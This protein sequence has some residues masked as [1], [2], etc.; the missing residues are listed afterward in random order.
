MDLA[1]YGQRKRVLK[2]GPMRHEIPKQVYPKEA[3]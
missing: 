3:I 1:Y 2:I